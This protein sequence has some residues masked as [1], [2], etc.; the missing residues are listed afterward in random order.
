MLNQGVVDAL[1][2]L[3]VYQLCLLLCEEK[4][5]KYMS[6]GNPTT[7]GSLFALLSF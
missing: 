3:L 1:V 2:A 6:M 4:P 7:L 5:Q